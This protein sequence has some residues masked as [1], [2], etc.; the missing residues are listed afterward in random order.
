MTVRSAHVE[1]QQ[2]RLVRVD[3]ERPQLRALDADWAGWMRPLTTRFPDA[4]VRLIDR[5]PGKLALVMI[6]GDQNPGV[7]WLVDLTTNRATEYGERYP[8]L[9]AERL[10][11]MEAFPIRAD[12]GK[13][14]LAYRV[15]PNGSVKGIVIMPHGGPWARDSWGYDPVVQYLAAHG[16]AVGMVNYRGS[17]GLGLRHLNAGRGEWDRNIINDINALR[18]GLK[19]GEL[20]NVRTCI[21]GFSF[22]G[23]AALM[24]AAMD[25]SG[26]DCAG[27][28]GGLVD[29]SGH[30][31]T[32]G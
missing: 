18:D 30:V 6:I 7:Y 24:S 32:L 10:A 1:G 15:V 31:T 9:N 4:D 26:Y 13:E 5:V 22:G 3:A 12:D 14:M 27:S 20:A 23:Y 8:W 21:I 17:R 19:K 2:A 29:V 25:H 28:I 11:A 16:W